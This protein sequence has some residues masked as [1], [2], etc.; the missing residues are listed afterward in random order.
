MNTTVT[1]VVA[2]YFNEINKKISWKV[3]VLTQKEL[4]L[5]W[6]CLT[7]LVLSKVTIVL[8]PLRLY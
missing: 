2:N 8:L 6:E 7:G 3:L 5:I 1:S 4:T